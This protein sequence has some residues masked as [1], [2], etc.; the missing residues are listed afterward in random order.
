MNY[1]FNITKL[2]YMN[3]FEND[4][5]DTKN[6]SSQVTIWVELNEKKKKNT[7]I[8]GLSYTK[9]ELND[10]LKNLKK[11]YGCNGSIKESEDTKD[12]KLTLYLQGDHIY[13]VQSYFNDLGFNNIIINN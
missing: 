3:P 13:N 12:N 7:C 2:I 1:S 4:E 10:H 9:S 5:N 11:K 8:S 6:N